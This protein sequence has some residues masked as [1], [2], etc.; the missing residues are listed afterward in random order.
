MNECASGLSNCTTHSSCEN[1]DGGFACP[2]SSGF[3]GNGLTSCVGN[4]SFLKI[5]LLTFSLL[6]PKILMNVWR[7]LLVLCC[8]LFVITHLVIM[9][10]FVQVAMREMEMFNVQVWL[11]S[12]LTLAS[13]AISKE[14]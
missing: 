4:F 7:V 10:V 8:I 2:C 13:L 3:R 9:I 1:T 14:K 5:C 6:F 11:I 12:F